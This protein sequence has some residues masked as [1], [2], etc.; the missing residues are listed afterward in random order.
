MATW[1]LSSYNLLLLW[2]VMT[3][4][5]SGHPS[6]HSRFFWKEHLNLLWG[7]LPSRP[8]H[9]SDS[10]PSSQW[11]RGLQRTSRSCSRPKGDL[12]IK[13]LRGWDWSPL[14]H[15]PTHAPITAVGGWGI[16]IGWT[17]VTCHLG[18]RQRA[19]LG[20]SA[21]GQ[22][23]A[24]VGEEGGAVGGLQPCHRAQQPMRRTPVLPSSAEEV[25]RS[26]WLSCSSRVT[27]G[28]GRV[29]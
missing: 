28:S 15:V 11:G 14:G 7:N 22:E 8:D 25:G 27:A 13:F 16:V 5:G 23:W 3:T 9:D 1:Q 26:E 2:P 10:S 24:R 17:W 19:G 12:F 4:R 6:P 21:L 29:S 20:A 18:R